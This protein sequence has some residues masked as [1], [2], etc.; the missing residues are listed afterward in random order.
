MNTSPSVE[1]RRTATVR[2]NIVW[3]EQSDGIVL[4]DPRQTRV[5]VLNKV[6]SD[7]WKQLM[8]GHDTDTIHANIVSS[9]DVSAEKAAADLDAFLTVLAAR[10]LISIE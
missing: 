6:A 7:I 9:Y 2:S 8:Q 1:K 4:M 3:R 5:R 10:E